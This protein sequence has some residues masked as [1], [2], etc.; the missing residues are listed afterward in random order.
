MVSKSRD[1]IKLLQAPFVC[2][3]SLARNWRV[4][5]DTA[6]YQISIQS[7]IWVVIWTEQN[8]EPPVKFGLNLFHHSDMWITLEKMN[9]K[10]LKQIFRIHPDRK[11]RGAFPPQHTSSSWVK[12]ATSQHWLASSCLCIFPQ[13]HTCFPWSHRLA[14]GALER[15]ESC[16]HAAYPRSL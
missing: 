1:S 15:A 12:E 11:G 8:K 6:K 9:K 10:T 3:K 13:R 5:A 7:N 14:P 16:H 4:W 2:K